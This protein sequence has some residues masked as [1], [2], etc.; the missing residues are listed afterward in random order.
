MRMLGLYDED[1]IGSRPE[2]IIRNE[3][4]LLDATG[5]RIVAVTLDRDGAVIL[6]RDR[7][8]YRPFAQPVSLGCSS[9]AG[10]TFLAAF[11][12]A[13]TAGADTPAAAEIASAAAIDMTPDLAAMG[14]LSSAKRGLYEAPSN[15]HANS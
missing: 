5:A 10:D 6:E 7:V 15:G 8:P 4:R 9:G 13:L 14:V 3:K 11:A 12:L 2:K 1:E